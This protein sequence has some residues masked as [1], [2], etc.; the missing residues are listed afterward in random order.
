[1]KNLVKLDFGQIQ[2]YTKNSVIYD[3]HLITIISVLYLTESGY[4]SICV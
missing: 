2:F 4:L 3:L 1:L